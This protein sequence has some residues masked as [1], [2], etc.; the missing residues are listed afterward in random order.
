MNLRRALLWL[1][2]WVGVVAGLIILVAATTGALL[3]FERPL[4]R[5]LEPALYPS[6]PGGQVSVTVE[7]ALAALR[8]KH[9]ALRV[10]GILL[11]RG[12]RDALRLFAG[13]RVF[14]CDPASGALLGS[15]PRQGGF[16]QT[17]TK[18]HT[19]LLLGPRG[20]TAVA[21]ATILTIALALS[22]LWLWW[23]LRIAWF[24]R[25]ANFRRFNFDLHAV[26]G[27]YSSLFLLVIAA[28]GVTLRYLH[29]EHP[30]IPM[31][32]LSSA[33]REPISIDSAIERAEAALP[34][35]RA[36]A[37]ELPGPNPSAPL[38][39]QLAFPEDGSPAGRSV[40]FLDRY[41]GGVLGVHN[42]RAG[43]LLER[44][45]NLQLSLHTGAVA[46]LPSQCVAFAT[47]LAVVLQVISGYVLW[48]KRA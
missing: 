42:A 13:D 48:W 14:H 39:V 22:G 27:L 28:T 43:M 6:K 10:Q 16:A 23:P 20:G 44:Y 32:P 9:P 35:A 15:R 12:D 37:L 18:L 36:V 47:C 29:V 45:G 1:H 5:W 38:R 4:H 34:G 21:V 11:P 41:E 30:R 26:A 8:E 33:G 46:G 40:V 24:R 25:G 7:P 31:A 2:R 17:L 19:S 3:V